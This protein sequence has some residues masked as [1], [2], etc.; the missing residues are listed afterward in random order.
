METTRVV[1]LPTGYR[2]CSTRL[3]SHPYDDRDTAQYRLACIQTGRMLLVSTT[4]RIRYI[5]QA[6]ALRHVDLH[7]LH[8]DESRKR[9]QRIEEGV[10]R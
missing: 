9:V 4:G 6:W 10:V 3:F 2:L 1:P 8:C 7:T 5:G